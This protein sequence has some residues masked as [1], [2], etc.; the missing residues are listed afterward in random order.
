MKRRAISP[1]LGWSVAG[2]VGLIVL[3]LLIR[4]SS[5]GYKESPPG[6]GDE[7]LADRMRC[8]PMTT[9]PEITQAT[10]PWGTRMDAEMILVA[11]SDRPTS[12]GTP[13]GFGYSY[14]DG[15]DT[16]RQ[17]DELRGSG[18]QTVPYQSKEHDAYDLGLIPTVDVPGYR[19]M[20]VW[21]TV[22]VA[23]EATGYADVWKAI[24]GT[25]GFTVGADGSLS[26]ARLIENPDA[27]TFEYGGQLR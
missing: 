22:H 18:Y 11:A 8:D 9:E 20:V 13:F 21:R 25:V 23:D 1:R 26:N 5:E 17:R 10:D 3:G 14:A 6:L 12:R 16:Q 19:E 15:A 2:L 7:A 4:E 24:C 27:G